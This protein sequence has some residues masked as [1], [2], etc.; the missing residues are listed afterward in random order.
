MKKLS[1]NAF[2]SNTLSKDQLRKLVGGW[3]CTYSDGKGG[4]FTERG[5]CASGVSNCKSTGEDKYN[6]F[7]L[8]GTCS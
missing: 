5:A 3:E 6:S 4:S 2:K 7:G 8:T 1:F